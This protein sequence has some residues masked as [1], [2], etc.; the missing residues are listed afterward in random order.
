MIFSTYVGWKYLR[1]M[2]FFR[3]L[4]TTTKHKLYAS[5]QAHLLHGNLSGLALTYLAT[6]PPY[7]ARTHASTLYNYVLPAAVNI[8]T[9]DVELITNSIINVWLV[10]KPL[11]LDP[12][13]S[14]PKQWSLEPAQEVIPSEADRSAWRVGLDLVSCE[15]MQRTWFAHG[16]HP[17]F[18]SIFFR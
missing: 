12:T 8:I 7:H 14:E 15:G 16:V 10:W 9:E 3:Q 11:I 1:P 5:L 6:H 4:S 18:F 13:E 17:I 2:T